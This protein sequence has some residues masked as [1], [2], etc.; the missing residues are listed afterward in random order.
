MAPHSAKRKIAIMGGTFDPI[1]IGHLVTAEA[2]AHE[3]AIDEV[4]FVPTGIPAHKASTHV[5]RSEHR[6]L[7]TVLATAANE[8]FN[9]SRIEIERQGTTYTIDTIKELSRYYGKN[10]KLYFITGADAIHEI[11]TWKNPTELLKLCTFIAV[12][13]PGYKRRALIEQVTVLKECYDAK[14]YFLEVPALAISSSDIR[15]RVQKSRTIK[16]LVTS[17][18]ENYIYKHKLYEAEKTYDYEIRQMLTT[19]VKEQLSN[20]RFEH[21]MGVV[22]LA[23]ELAAFYQEDEDKVFTAALFHDIAKERGGQAC[24]DLCK[25]Y[26]VAIDAFE[27]KNK[28]LLH[29]KAGAIILEKKWGIKDEVIL[30]SIRNHTLGAPHMTRI[31]KIIFLADQ[32]EE[33]RKPFE[34]IEEIRRFLKIDLNRAMY[35]ALKSTKTYIQETLSQQVH[36]MIDVLLEEYKIYE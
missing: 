9:V 20:S 13:R 26:D 25:E 8:K 31:E 24:Y 5:T 4:V 30:K 2:V 32:L 6:Y 34:G 36:P 35:L 27:R 11:L 22:K 21:T 10:V 3:Y 1:H 28:Y 16:Y 33:G 18:V 23:V 15:E 29:G 12:T 17:A 14:V 7:M 19:Y